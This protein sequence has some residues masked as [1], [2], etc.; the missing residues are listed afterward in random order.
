MSNN[1]DLKFMA[2]SYKSARLTP[3]STI[4]NT[5]ETDTNKESVKQEIKMVGRHTKRCST[6]PVM[7]ELKIKMR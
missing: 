2:K 5:Q 4:K 3:K 1:Y 7:G 6:V